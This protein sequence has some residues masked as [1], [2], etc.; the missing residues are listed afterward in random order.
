[1][2]KEI[3]QCD[4]IDTFQKSETYKNNF[5]YDGLV[6]LFEYFEQYEES[7]GERIELDV[8]AICCEYSEYSSAIKVMKEYAP[9]TNPTEAEA[10]AWLQNRT[11]VIQFD[12]GVIIADF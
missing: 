10:L 4:F 5:S 9:N 12:R 8:V 1:M 3:N 2:Y 6:A 7:T 11:Q